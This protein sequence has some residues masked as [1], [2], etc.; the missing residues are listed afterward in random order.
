V[1]LNRGNIQSLE[2][3]DFELGKRKPQVKSLND[4]PIHKKVMGRFRVKNGYKVLPSNRFYNHITLFSGAGEF[5]GSTKGID[6]LLGMILRF[7]EHR[8][9]GRVKNHQFLSCE[10]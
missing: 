2:Q 3:G 6:H 10:R 9:S 8:C 7:G 1:K 5:D 4:N